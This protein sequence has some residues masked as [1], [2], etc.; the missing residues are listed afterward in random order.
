EAEPTEIG[1]PGDTRPGRRLLGRRDD[2]G[3]AAVDRLV[4]L[5][6]E[7]DRLEVLAAAVLVRQPLALLP[8]VVEVE[9]RRDRIDPQAVGVMLPHPVERVGEEEIP[10]LATAEVEDQ[11]SPVWMRTSPWVLVLVQRGAV[12]AR[13]RP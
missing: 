6:Q 9:H 5:L 3:L 12:E 11:R 7:L 8:R 1:R 10:H 4:H 13:E 2:P